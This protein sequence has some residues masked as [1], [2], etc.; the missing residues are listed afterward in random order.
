ML[1]SVH[2]MSLCPPDVHVDSLHTCV[3]PPPPAAHPTS[4]YPLRTLVWCHPLTRCPSTC[5]SRTPVHPLIWHSSAGRPSILLPCPP[6][7]SLVCPPDIHLSAPPVQSSIHLSGV[8]PPT[9]RPSISAPPANSSVCSS[10]TRPPNQHL[11][12]SSSHTSIHPASVCPT[13]VHLYLLR[14]LLDY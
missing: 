10:G 7:C 8:H 13:D 1:Y 5:S 3:R 2:P 12:T 14:A 4:I 11:Y 9:Q 6:I